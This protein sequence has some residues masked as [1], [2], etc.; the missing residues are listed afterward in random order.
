MFSINIHRSRKYAKKIKITMN[1][2]PY[3]RIRTKT[4]YLIVKKISTESV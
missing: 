2:Y 3:E 1:I 4:R